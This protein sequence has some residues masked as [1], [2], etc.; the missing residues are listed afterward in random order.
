MGSVALEP[1]RYFEIA[2]A[3]AAPIEPLE[4]RKHEEK[5]INVKTNKI[6]K[7]KENKL[8]VLNCPTALLASKIRFDGTVAVQK[9]GLLR[10]R[11]F[12]KVS[13]NVSSLDMFKK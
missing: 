9:C 10:S 5:K 3:R 12:Y 7:K 6:T 4:N 1:R 13:E 11:G 8:T 2:L